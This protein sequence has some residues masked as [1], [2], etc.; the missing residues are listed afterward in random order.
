MKNMSGQALEQ[1]LIEMTSEGHQRD[2]LIL[3]LRYNTGGNVHDEV[4]KFLSQK[5]Y[6]QWK[7]RGGALQVSQ[8]LHLLPARWYCS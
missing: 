4:L 2:G 7:Y 8:I 3:D 5:P 6:L 1:F